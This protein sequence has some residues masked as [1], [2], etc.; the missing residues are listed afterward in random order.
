MIIIYFPKTLGGV[1]FEK[2]VNLLGE[3]N[4]LSE[5]TPES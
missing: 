4:P 1:S 5:L 3:E 2:L